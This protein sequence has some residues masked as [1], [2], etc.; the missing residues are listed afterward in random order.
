MGE[1]IIITQNTNTLIKSSIPTDQCMLDV[2]RA[3][4]S[5]GGD[6]RQWGVQAVQVEKEWAVVTL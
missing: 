4:P 3:H 1:N 6:V 5:G 2:V